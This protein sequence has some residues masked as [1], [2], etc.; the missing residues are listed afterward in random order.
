MI[1]LSFGKN[2]GDAYQA[3]KNRDK[4]YW[5]SFLHPKLFYLGLTMIIFEFILQF[6]A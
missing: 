3:D 6:I 1:A 4:V 2:L 5:A